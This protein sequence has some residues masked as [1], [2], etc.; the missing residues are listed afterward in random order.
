MFL[1]NPFFWGTPPGR[2]TEKKQLFK[3]GDLFLHLDG[4]LADRYRALLVPG[5]VFKFIMQ[6]A[7][8]TALAFRRPPK[9]LIS[10]NEIERSHV[11]SRCFFSRYF[12]YFFWT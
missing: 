7:K 6:P 11:N 12:L 5:R 4:F 3:S 10:L 9:K 2:W 1:I 8:K